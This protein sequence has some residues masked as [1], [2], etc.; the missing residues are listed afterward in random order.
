MRDSRVGGFAVAGG[1]VLFA[2]KLTALAS[3][4]GAARLAALVLAPVLGRLAMTCVLAMY[5]YARPAGA[6]NAFKNAIRPSHVWFAFLVGVAAAA[7]FGP[8][9]VLALVVALAAA[10]AIGR[11]AARRLGGLTG[12][13]YGFICECVEALTFLLAASSLTQERFAWPI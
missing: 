8:G 12:D 6:G 13:T 11:Y 3:A 9:G 5:P 4:A 1:L 2:V 7:P 10:A